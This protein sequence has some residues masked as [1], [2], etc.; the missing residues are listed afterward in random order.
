M[1]RGEVVGGYRVI[2][3]PTNNGGGNCVWAFGERDKE[4]VFIKCFLEPKRPRPDS[5]ASEKSKRLRLQACEEFEKRHRTIMKMLK[6]DASG[7]GN[8][9]LAK[10]LFYE[11]STYYKITERIE[12]S[13]LAT[14]ADLDS[15]QKRVLLRTLVLS[16]KQLHDIGVVHGD[17]KLDNV[18]VQKRSKRAFYTTKLID[19]DDSY[20]S[21]HPPDAESIGGDVRFGAPEWQRY[22]RQDGSV[23]PDFLTTA[24]DIF[25]L[26]LMA[27]YYLTGALPGF[28]DGYDSAADA[29]NAEKPLRLDG[30]LA[31]ETREL[32]KA[33]TA[34]SPGSRP[35]VDVLLER[36]RDERIFVLNK[37]SE[38]TPSPPGSTVPREP[39]PSRVSTN[40][41]GKRPVAPS[42]T[43]PVKSAGK[44]TSR[45]RIN[46]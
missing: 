11:G 5:T 38:F 46:R 28:P 26:G 3:E 45:V 33:M 14:P 9:V 36:L 7:G 10:E 27:H 40:M 22:V 1:K 37:K 25:A 17:L 24:S 42:V 2:T 31:S 35:G 20:V 23:R 15:R 8:L 12:T 13:S 16:L 18:L 29:V 30:R 19:F 4:Q 44:R 21:G 39:K 34:R 32:I 6:P 41:N 43:E